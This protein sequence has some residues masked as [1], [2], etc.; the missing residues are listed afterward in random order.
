MRHRY[1]GCG[2]G[3]ARCRPTRR[4]SRNSTSRCSLSCSSRATSSPAAGGGLLASRR[5]R[6]LLYIHCFRRVMRDC[7]RYLPDVKEVGKVLKELNMMY[8]ADWGQDSLVTHQCKTLSH[9]HLRGINKACSDR[10]W[11]RDPWFSASYLARLLACAQ[12]TTRRPRASGKTRMN[13]KCFNR[14]TFV[15]LDSELKPLPAS[16][17]TTASRKDG[18][19]LQGHCAV[20]VRLVEL[21]G[22]GSR[23]SSASTPPAGSTSCSGGGSTSRRARAQRQRVAHGRLSRRPATAHRTPRTVSRRSA[24]GCFCTPSDWRSPEDA[25]GRTFHSWKGA[26]HAWPLPSARARAAS[27]T[28]IDNNVNKQWQWRTGRRKSPS[29]AT[30]G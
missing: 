25:D 24:A 4:S 27:D 2:A 12:R 10:H 16:P 8:M 26:G 17:A 13:K 19:F 21:R 7:G 3:R 28:T 29:G 11:R 18:D 22:G 23:S 1:A 9:G 30:R 5:G 20:Q 6:A 15:W 14:G